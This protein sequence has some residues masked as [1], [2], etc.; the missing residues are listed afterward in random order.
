MIHSGCRILNTYTFL[1]QY[2]A[3]QQW[4][5]LTKEQINSSRTV[6]Q[7][8]STIRQLEQT[9]AQ[10]VPDEQARFDENIGDMQCRTLAAIM[11]FLDLQKGYDMSPVVRLCERQTLLNEDMDRVVAKKGEV[12]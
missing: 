9:R 12:C 10:I 5:L 1:L 8:K 2:Q 6:K 11:E 3:C 4:D 7:L